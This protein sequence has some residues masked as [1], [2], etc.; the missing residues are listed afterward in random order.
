MD[1]ITNSPGLR[2]IAE[3]I[4]K[5]LDKKTILFS[6]RNV[7]RSWREIVDNRTFWMKMLGYIPWSPIHVIKGEH[8]YKL[9]ELQLQ[10]QKQLEGPNIEVP[11]IY[12]FDGRSPSRHKQSFF[13]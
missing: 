1:V 3:N 2:N 6:C 11:I 4:F 5:Y 13:I 10:L 9:L 8:D 7:S 12:F